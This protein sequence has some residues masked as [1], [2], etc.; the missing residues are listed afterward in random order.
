MT[1][2]APHLAAFLRDYLPRQR[3]CSGHTCEAYAYSFQLLIL[4]A[5]ERLGVSPSALSLE[6]L[7]IPLVVAFLEHIE[8]ARGN[9]PKTRNARLAAIKSFAH[10]IEYRVPSAV[11]QV[12]RLLAI[13]PKKTDEA[14][15]PYLDR[16]ELQALLDAPDPS[17][18]SGTRDRAMLHLAFAA[19]LRVSEL[20]G[21]RLD[22]MQMHPDPSV[23]VR[24]KGR[25]ERVIPL[26][27]ETVCALRAWLEIR[28]DVVA[29]ELFLNARGGPLTRS[30]F[31]YVLAKH[32]ESTTK[33]CPSLST[34][35][36]SPHVLRHT[37]AMH[38]LQATRDVRKVALWLGHATIK[39]TEIYL[40][41]DPTEKL[42]ALDAS[43]SPA[44][45]PGRFTAPDKLLTMLKDEL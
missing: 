26:W 29:S 27:K 3:A 7:D 17:T 22:D 5:A 8:I 10:F 37:C 1:A 31:E 36:V 9:S 32:V 15:V 44:L 39:S 18:R 41:A 6:Q 45:R 40:R 19:G 12:R 14:L 21:M 2:L 13:P 20:V 24:G 16:C 43:V 33:G 23:H 30:G 35:R 25:R 38:I 34:K 4:F 28:C 42:A 11:D